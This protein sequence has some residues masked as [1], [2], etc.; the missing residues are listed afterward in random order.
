MK[1][2]DQGN[3]VARVKL[4]GFKTAA[5]GLLLAEQHRHFQRELVKHQH[6]MADKERAMSQRCNSARMCVLLQRAMGRIE[7]GEV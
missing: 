7:R 3:K 4:V 5:S 6:V 2:E 1:N